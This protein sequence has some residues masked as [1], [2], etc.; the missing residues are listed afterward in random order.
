MHYRT[1]PCPLRSSA[2]Q[3]HRSAHGPGVSRARWIHNPCP[4][5][6]ALPL[7]HTHPHLFQHIGDISPHKTIVNRERS[8]DWTAFAKIEYEDTAASIVYF[9]LTGMKFAQPLM[10]KPRYEHFISSWT[11]KQKHVLFV[12]LRGGQHIHGRPGYP[13]EIPNLKM[14]GVAQTIMINILS[15]AHFHNTLAKYR[16]WSAAK[17]C[18]ILNISRSNIREQLIVIAHTCVRPTVNQRFLLGR[19]TDSAPER[20]SAVFCTSA[21]LIAATTGPSH[22]RP[23]PLPR[24]RPRAAISFK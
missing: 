5:D 18:A 10:G 7:S 4:L 3:H 1:T 12:D 19:K 21:M 20:L 9:L 6:A 16:L 24:P 14:N 15:H 17:W 13:V 2:S 8:H 11:S 23:Q 22:P